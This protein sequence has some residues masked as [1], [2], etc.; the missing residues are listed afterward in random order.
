MRGRGLQASLNAP[1]DRS[2]LPPGF[3]SPGTPLEFLIF[4]GMKPQAGSTRPTHR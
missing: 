1:F 2:T 3:S 4:P